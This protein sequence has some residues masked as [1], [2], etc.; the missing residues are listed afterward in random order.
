MSAN[1][2]EQLAVE[3]YEYRGYFVRRNVPVG[4]VAEGGHEA[5]LGIVAVE[6]E[7]GRLVHIEASMDAHSWEVREQRFAKKFAAG[8]THLPAI[9]GGLGEGAVEQIA[10][11]ALGSRVNHPTLGGAT[12]LTLADFMA[13]ILTELRDRSGADVSVAQQFPILRTLQ[14]VAEHRRALLPILLDQDPRQISF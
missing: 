13:E 7:A 11:V 12:V 8:R 5:E 4:P 14:F 2:L 3:W 6:P 1:Y 9:F 10:L